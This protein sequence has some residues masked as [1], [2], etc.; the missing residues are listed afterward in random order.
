ME[1]S[2][3]N[4]DSNGEYHRPKVYIAFLMIRVYLTGTI[5]YIFY[6]LEFLYHNENNEKSN[7]M[8]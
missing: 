3:S 4:Y 2:N 8:Q 1:V 5:G 6:H 7:V